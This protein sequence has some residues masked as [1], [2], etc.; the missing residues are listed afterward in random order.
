M[1]AS[2]KLQ[3]GL[4]IDAE[5]SERLDLAMAI[6]EKLAS[7]RELR[8]WNGLG[9]VLQAY[10]KRAPKVIDWL[11]ALAIETQ[12]YFMVRLVKGAYWDTEIKSCLLYTSPSPRD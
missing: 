1:F 3:Y 11:N 4:T 10:L 7:E 9:F 5:E 6:F 2:E 8:N 12:S